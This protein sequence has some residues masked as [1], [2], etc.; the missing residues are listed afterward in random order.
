MGGVLTWTTNGFRRCRVPQLPGLWQEEV[1]LHL[2]GDSAGLRVRPV[3][4][5]VT[6]RP[7]VG[8]GKGSP[9]TLMELRCCR[10]VSSVSLLGKEELSMPAVGRQRCWDSK[11]ATI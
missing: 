4:T 7:G 8:W 1:R 11:K 2:W 5:W 6:W 3:R 10:N 9:L